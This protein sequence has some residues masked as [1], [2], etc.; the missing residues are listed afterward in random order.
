MRGVTV[1]VFAALAGAAPSEA[2]AQPRN[3]VF[4]AVNAAAQPTKNPFTDRFDFDANRE[5]GT[6][7]VEYPVTGGL[8][9]DG[10]IAVRLWGDLAAGVAVSHFTR[11]DTVATSS[12]VPH[13]F[14]FDMPRELAGD[15]TVTRTERAVHVQAVYRFVVRAPV[16]VTLFAGPSFV[17]VEQDLVSAVEYDE[18]FPFD[19]VTFRRAQAASFSGS[20]IGINAGVDLAWMFSRHVGVGGLARIA[21]ASVDVDVPGGRT[22]TLDAGGFTAGGGLRIAF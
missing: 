14:F 20:A 5:I 4:I 15:A 3:R 13:P 9:V 8:I 6:T 18:T 19:T 1:L 17:T 16:E 22:K 11:D 21:R 7:D 10:S 2:F 12:R